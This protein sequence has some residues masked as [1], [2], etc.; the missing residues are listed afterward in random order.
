MGTG[1]TSA[2]SVP[3]AEV[4]FAAQ[5][6]A[7][8]TPWVNDD[9]DWSDCNKDR[10][11]DYSS[12]TEFVYSNFIVNYE[13]YFEGNISDVDGNLTEFEWKFESLDWYQGREI[14]Y[15]NE[16]F[17]TCNH[18]LDGGN[19]SE[20]RAYCTRD[21]RHGPW[22][23]SLRAKDDDGYWGSW[24]DPYF[25]YVSQ[26]IEIKEISSTESQIA[27]NQ[28]SNAQKMHYYDDNIYIVDVELD[29]ILVMDGYTHVITSYLYD[30][31]YLNYVS[32]LTFDDDGYMYTLSRPSGNE[33]AETFVCKW[34][35]TTRIGCNTG[36]V[37]YG[38]A[39]THYEEQLFVLQTHNLTSYN[40]VII[41][42]LMIWIMRI[43]LI[44]LR[45]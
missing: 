11:S 44:I 24:S 4:D 43:I 34:S 14:E 26:R 15:P 40:H 45:I 33:S 9:A 35:G 17:E 20:Y 22:N 25:V 5:V 13:I 30:S 1:E 10:Y 2:D 19:Q 23:I 6:K 37:S 27:H 28:F 21:L 32:D 36:H 7:C 29:S 38:S 42:S 39:L 8:Y 16:Y 18:E 3:E 12:G 31:T 41:L